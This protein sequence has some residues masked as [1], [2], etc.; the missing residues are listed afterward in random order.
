MGFLCLESLI[1]IWQQYAWVAGNL[2]KNQKNLSLRRKKSAGPSYPE[3][4]GVAAPGW[5]HAPNPYH[6]I[7]SFGNA[8]HALPEAK[9]S[10]NDSVPIRE[11][12][13]THSRMVWVSFAH[14][15]RTIRESGQ[16]SVRPDWPL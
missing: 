9:W 3:L 10:A 1:T 7:G 14:H 4:Q 15:R 6:V 5:M 16:S 12:F 2:S 13:L 8:S 11:P